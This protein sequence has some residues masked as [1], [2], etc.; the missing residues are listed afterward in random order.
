MLGEPRKPL[1][2]ALSPKIIGGLLLIM[3]AIEGLRLF[4]SGEPFSW[5]RLTTSLAQ[6]YLGGFTMREA[7]KRER[8]Q[9]AK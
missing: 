2:S 3:G 7:R 8:E 5:W 1:G 6:L 4:F 9:E